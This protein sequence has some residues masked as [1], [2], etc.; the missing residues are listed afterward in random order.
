MKFNDILKKITGGIPSNWSWG[1]CP[2]LS[3]TVTIG[4]NKNKFDF[5]KE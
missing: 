2:A 5:F 1:K 3:I 4:V